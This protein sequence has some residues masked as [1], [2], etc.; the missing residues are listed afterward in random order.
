MIKDQKPI[1]SFQV[2]V[3]VLHP[4]REI[5]KWTNFISPKYTKKNAIES[6]KN[7]AIAKKD[8]S[9]VEEFINHLN[10]VEFIQQK[11]LF[12]ITNQLP[13]H[14]GII[15]HTKFESLCVESI[16]YDSTYRG[17]ILF[18]VKLHKLHL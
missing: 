5:E 1:T 4:V 7:T 17:V 3:Q 14:K 6:F 13:F 10:F 11:I 9:L 2:Q 12:I 15:L 18:K 8:S 16:E